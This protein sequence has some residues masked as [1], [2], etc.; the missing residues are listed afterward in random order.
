MFQFPAE[1][2]LSHN[3]IQAETNKV[4]TH[5]P[6]HWRPRLL[7]V[8]GFLQGSQCI[9][10]PILY[11]LEASSSALVWF[12]KVTS[13][14]NQEQHMPIRQVEVSVIS[15]L[16]FQLLLVAGP[17]RLFCHLPFSYV[18]GDNKLR[19]SLLNLSVMSRC[20]ATGGFSIYLA[21]LISRN[22]S[23]HVIF[24][25][26]LSEYYFTIWYHRI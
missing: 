26:S 6:F 20:S 13:L 19:G 1:T 10:H 15:M 12:I 23:L 8:S 22:G 3:R 16:C 11:R 4:P 25:K 9:F 17:Q 21:L 5:L 18:L 24:N 14:D 2:F 7:R